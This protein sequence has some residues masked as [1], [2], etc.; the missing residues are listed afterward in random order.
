M[1]SIAD[2]DADRTAAVSAI[3]AVSGQT[4]VVAEDNGGGLTLTAADGRNIVMGFT[5]AGVG[6]ADATDFG[7]ANTADT[8]TPQTTYS[9]VTLSSECV[10]ILDSSKPSTGFVMRSSPVL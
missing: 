4:G 2:Q 6:V 8:A 5:A 3:N 1:T 7:I 10:V 9:S